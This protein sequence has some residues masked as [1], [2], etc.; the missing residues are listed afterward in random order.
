M[1]NVFFISTDTLKKN[2]SINENVDD[3]ELRFCIQTAQNVKIQETLGYPLY[4]KIVNDVSNDTLTGNYLSLM[5]DYIVP[6]TIYWSY[7][8]GLDNFFVKWMN[9]G[10]VSNNNEQGSPIDYKTFN[11]LKNSAKNNAEYY[12]E[13]MRKY[14]CAKSNLFPEYL[15]YEEGKLISEKG[16]GFKSNII[17]DTKTRRWPSWYGKDPTP[18]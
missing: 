17:L 18:K 6:A 14:L 1:S 11:Y 7:Y 15:E 3:N 10:L 8:F 2:T 9:V 12:S 13:L 4:N 16:S 5:N